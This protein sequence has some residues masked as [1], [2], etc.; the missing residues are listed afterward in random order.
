MPVIG[1]L[2]ST[3]SG[4]YGYRLEAFREGLKDA[5][6]V[7]GQNVSMEYRWAENQID[8][9]PALA[10]DLAHRKVSVIAA[11]GSPASALAA[12]LATASIPIVFMNAADPV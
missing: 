3:S 1:F 5:R 12:K 10:A 11:G 2:N 4:Q 9:L 8:R 6:Y 7:E